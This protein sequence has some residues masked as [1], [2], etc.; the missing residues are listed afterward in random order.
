MCTKALVESNPKHTLFVLEDLTGVRNATE[1]VK[2]KNRY[3][4]YRGRYD[5]EQ[6]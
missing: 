4:L 5:L 1:R 3:V 2:T 6:K